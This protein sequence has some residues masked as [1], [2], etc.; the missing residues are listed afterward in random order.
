[1]KGKLDSKDLAI[2]DK[3]P[4]VNSDELHKDEGQWALFIDKRV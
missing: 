4:A 1:M 2:L 3:N